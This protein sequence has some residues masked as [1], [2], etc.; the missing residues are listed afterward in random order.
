MNE[1]NVTLGEHSYVGEGFSH[2]HFNQG[3]WVYIG[4]F[5]SIAGNVTIYTSGNH[6]MD[7]VTTFPFKALWGIGTFNGWDK[8]DVVIGNDV[9]IGDSVTILS[10]VTIGDGAVI[11][12][13]AVVAKDVP[14]YGVV[15]GNPAKVVKYRFPSDKIRELLEMKWWDWPEHKIKDKIEWLTT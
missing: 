10:G 5:C 14:A 15:V 11:G 13:A 2:K 8:G 1:P 7:T 6:R 12:T 9:W 3:N 4:K